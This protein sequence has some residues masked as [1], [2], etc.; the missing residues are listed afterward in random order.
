MV[1][2]NNRTLIIIF[3]FSFITFILSC[4]GF[5]DSLSAS[6]SKLLYSTLGYTNKWSKT[7]GPS[8]FVRMTNNFSALG[9][10]ELVLI[11]SIFIYFYLDLARKK[12]HSKNFLFTI[13]SGIVF[14]L[15]VKTITSMNTANT[16]IDFL[17]ETLTEFPSGHTFIATVMYLAIAQ[18]LGSRKKSDQVNKY[19]IIVATIVI[20]LVGVSRFLGGAHTIT[21]VIAGWSLGL[22]WYIFA[23]LFFKLD[24]KK[25]SKNKT[26]SA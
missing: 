25:S 2:K 13:G 24:Y 26:I 21:E 22:C 17:S 19:L 16:Q 6:G 14:I 10:R 8:W 3:V 18:Q 1:S 9:S 5:F 12:I 20:V 15:I 11:F 23:E 7:Y 4:T